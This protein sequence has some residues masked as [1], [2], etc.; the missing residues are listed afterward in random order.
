MINWG[1]YIWSVSENRV[2]ESAL[3]Y[4]ISPLFSVAIGVVSLGE[5]LHRLQWIAVTSASIG[6]VVLTFNYGSLPWIA[7]VL[8]GTW[9]LY[10]SVK[11]HLN[12]GSVETLSI[13]TLIF[14]L[15]CAIY[16][17]F[18][19]NKGSGQ[20]GHGVGISLLLFFGGVVTIVP[21]LLFNGANT[22][23][24]LSTSGLL[25]YITPTLMFLIGIFVNHEDMSNGKFI[26]FIFIWVAL[27]V[28]GK[29]LVKSGRTSDD[30]IA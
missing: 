24:P 20:L 27:V 26:G 14:F 11:K 16:L 10:A 21:L 2:I 15:P 25:Q 22:R 28:L 18:L 4:Y 12:L 13:E 9:G 1:V 8:A 3:G 29:D 17:G 6:V 30:R 23:L 5:K 19:E 7:L